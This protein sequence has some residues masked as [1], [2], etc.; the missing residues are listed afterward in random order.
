[1]DSFPAAAFTYQL[2]LTAIK[3]SEK[4]NCQLTL[5]EVSKS[6]LTPNLWWLL[7]LHLL[8]YYFFIEAV[9]GST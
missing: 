3:D 7:L 8:F 5:S 1:M 4:V 2:C 9:K 6:S